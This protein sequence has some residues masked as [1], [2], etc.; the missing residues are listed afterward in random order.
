MEC[1]DDERQ[2]YRRVAETLHSISFRCLLAPALSLL[3][4]S[5]RETAPVRVVRGYL[6]SIPV[7]PCLERV[8]AFKYVDGDG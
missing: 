1:V 5:P 6:Y 8:T 7:G 4:R 3:K 2:G